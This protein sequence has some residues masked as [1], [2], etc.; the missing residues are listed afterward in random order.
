MPRLPVLRREV[1]VV[2]LLLG[3]VAV[4]TA[5]ETWQVTRL[6]TAKVTLFDCKDG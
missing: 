6:R 2:V 1:I 3:S 4:A 5:Q